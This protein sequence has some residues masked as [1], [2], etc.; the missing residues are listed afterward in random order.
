[1]RGKIKIVS[2]NLS[3]RFSKKLTISC[4]TIRLLPEYGPGGLV[5]APLYEETVEG[6][7]PF[8]GDTATIQ[9]VRTVLLHHCLERYN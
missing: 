5:P 1:M 9:P 4:G 2:I 7:E 8:E 6:D 3:P